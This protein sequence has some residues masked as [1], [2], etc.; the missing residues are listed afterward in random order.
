MMMD[1]DALDR[2]LAA[3]PLD[4]PPADLQQRILARTVYAPQ[5]AFRGWELWAVGTL[6]AV[7][8]WLCWL[9][10]SAPHAVTRIVTAF[11]HVVALSGLDS[12]ATVLWLVAGVST[13]WWL[14]QLSVPSQTA[15]RRIKVQ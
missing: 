1:D 15:R 5:P 12:T 14:T 4:D 10:A 13:T 7:A 8:T 2:A 6:I 9:V 3:L 11:S